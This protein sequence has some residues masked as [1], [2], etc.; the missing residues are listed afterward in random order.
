MPPALVL[1]QHSPSFEGALLDLADAAGVAEPRVVRDPESIEVADPLGAIVAVGGREHEAAALVDRVAAAVEAPIVVVG[2]K[3]DHHVVAAL[4]RA[5]AEAFFSLPDDLAMLRGWLEERVSRAR[6]RDK[7]AALSRAEA[8]HYDFGGI[9]GESPGLRD[10]LRRLARIIPRDGVTV[11][12]TGETGTGKELAAQALHYNGPRSAGPFVEVNCAALP[13]SLLEAELFGYEKGAFTDARTAKPGL[14]E[15]A[16]RGTLFLDEV[17]D[18][19]P[20][21]QVKLLKVLEDR[22]VRRLGSVKSRTVDIR[23]VAATHVDLTAAVQA[24][25]FR[26][27]LFFRLNVI[28]VH[29]PP[30][31]D[32]EGDVVLL[33]RHF[34]R[35]AAERHGLEVPRIPADVE[36]RLRAYAWPGNVRE[37]RNAME[38]AVLLGDGVVDP[39]DLALGEFGVGAAGA[40]GP[41]P[42]PATLA[43]IERAAASAALD[44]TDGNKSAAAHLLGISRTRLYRLLA[45]A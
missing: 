9:V 19:A 17:G 6:A 12:I 5:G 25:R 42:F 10:A 45:D 29:L 38:R 2:A 8:R 36:A 34:A 40:T 30:L 41:L 20:A 22:S 18:L 13:A 15:A 32:R 27:D 11:L 7:A 44:H 31:R 28:P 21:L 4:V 39:H 3:T 1:L 16:H 24:G 37:L 33:A 14:F 43:E 26:Q 35:T 23:L